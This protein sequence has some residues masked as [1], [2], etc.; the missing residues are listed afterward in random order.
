[1]WK[2]VDIGMSLIVSYLMVTPRVV[3]YLLVPCTSRRNRLIDPDAFNIRMG[4]PDQPQKPTNGD[5]KGRWGGNGDNGDGHP[6]ASDGRDGLGRFLPG[7]SGNPSGRKKGHR[8]ISDVLRQKLAEEHTE[9]G[10]PLIEDIADELIK[11]ARGGDR[12]AMSAIS[13]I[14][15][16]TEGKATQRVHSLTQEIE[17]NIDLSKLN[18]SEA[19]QL[20]DLLSEAQVTAE[21]GSDDNG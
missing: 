13:E 14:I 6:D 11:F 4:P 2:V 9:D 16:R 12:L 21:Q 7:H 3:V 17:T 10:K 15:D 5:G 8:Y 19:S 20:L 1:M 18:E